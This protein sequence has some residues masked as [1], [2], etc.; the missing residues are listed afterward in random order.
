MSAG[1]YFTR[2][3]ATMLAACSLPWCSLSHLFRNSF[4]VRRLRPR[5]RL[6]RLVSRSLCRRRVLTMTLSS[7]ERR[8]FRCCWRYESNSI[9]KLRST[10]VF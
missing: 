3:R 10:V 9:R 4:Q 1:G 8:A 5:D 2:V 6:H 7:Q